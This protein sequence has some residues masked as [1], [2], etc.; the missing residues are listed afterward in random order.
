M[1]RKIKLL[2]LFILL[3]LT[4][5]LSGCSGI[6]SGEGFNIGNLFGNPIVIIAL[7]AMVFYMWSHRGKK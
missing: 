7:I 6:G 5:T 4:L 3:T 1:K 2:G